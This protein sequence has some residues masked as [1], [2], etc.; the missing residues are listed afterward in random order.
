VL[1]HQTYKKLFHQTYKKLYTVAGQDTVLSLLSM[2][3]SAP[4]GFTKQLL[5]F[6][7]L[8]LF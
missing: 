4:L 8:A 6:Q 3:Q 2:Y 1:F 5:L 7:W